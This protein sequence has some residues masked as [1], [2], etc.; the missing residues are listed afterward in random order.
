MNTSNVVVDERHFCHVCHY[1]TAHPDIVCF[2]ELINEMDKDSHAKG[3]PRMSL[4]RVVSLLTMQ[5]NAYAQKHKKSEE[6]V[7]GFGEEQ[8]KEHILKHD[9]SFKWLKQ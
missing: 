4:Q 8:V 1:Y 2:G 9:L 6:E 5:L 3:R 7:T